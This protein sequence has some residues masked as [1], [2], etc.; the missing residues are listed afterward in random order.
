MPLRHRARRSAEHQAPR[1]VPHRD[2]WRGLRTVPPL[3]RTRRLASLPSHDREGLSQMDSRELDRLV[4]QTELT[5]ASKRALRHVRSRVMSGVL[6]DPEVGNGYW[7]V[8]LDGARLRFSL[9][10]DKHGRSKD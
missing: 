1:V 6:H 8:R 2:W 7:E 4:S 9:R 5:P 10:R 3:R